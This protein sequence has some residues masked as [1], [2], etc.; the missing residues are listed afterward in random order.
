MPR[1]KESIFL[2]SVKWGA[3]LQSDHTSKPWGWWLCFPD[4]C[5]LLLI[6]L[7]LFLLRMSI[8]GAL[9]PGRLDAGG[10]AAE[11]HHS[12][13][14]FLDCW[15]Q[16]DPDTHQLAWSP[17]YSL[18]KWSIGLKPCSLAWHILCFF[19]AAVASFPFLSAHQFRMWLFFPREIY[20][21]FPKGFIYFKDV[22]I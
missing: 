2:F 1:K 15:K 20:S 16:W 13:R 7:P 18:L 12:P 4:S 11:W 8:S 6:P 17:E 21:C 10:Q 3:P 5:C 22:I 19:P 14:C 9:A